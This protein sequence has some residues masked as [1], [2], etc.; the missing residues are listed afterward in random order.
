[1]LIRIEDS[2]NFFGAVWKWKT[3]KQAVEV[4]HDEKREGRGHEKAENDG[5]G[6]ASPPLAHLASYFPFP[7]AEIEADAHGHGEHAEDRG[8]SG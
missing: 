3:V 2:S 8:D 5:R 6:H 4:G 7:F 1:M